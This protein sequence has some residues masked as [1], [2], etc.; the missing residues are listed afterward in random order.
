MS[1]LNGKFSIL[2]SISSLTPSFSDLSI[3]EAEIEF[4]WI[5][6]RNLNITFPFSKIA[7]TPW[8]DRKIRFVDNDGDQLEFSQISLD[9]YSV[10]M[11]EP[12]AVKVIFSIGDSKRSRTVRQPVII[13]QEF[14]DDSIPIRQRLSFRNQNNPKQNYVLIENNCEKPITAEVTIDGQMKKTEFVISGYP[15]LI[16]LI[17]RKEWIASTDNTCVRLMLRLSGSEGNRIK[18]DFVLSPPGIND[19]DTDLSDKRAFIEDGCQN[20]ELKFKELPPGLGHESIEIHSKGIFIDSPIKNK[21]LRLKVPFK[22]SERPI[23]FFVNKINRTYKVESFNEIS[24]AS[25]KITHDRKNISFSGPHFNTSLISID[26]SGDWEG[27]LKVNVLTYNNN[28]W[29]SIDPGEHRYP[30]RNNRPRTISFKWLRNNLPDVDEFL[31]QNFLQ[32]DLRLK[33]EIFS[34]YER[35]PISFTTFVA[36]TESFINIIREPYLVEGLHESVMG[37]AELDYA[38]YPPDKKYEFEFHDK[39]HSLTNS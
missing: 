17:T 24:E 28:L 18:R 38:Q 7:S 6:L 22:F 2:D 19:Y 8:D 1:G 3:E 23:E 35:S 33:F 21:K 15:N 12:I 34:G 25:C 39:K 11:D 31:Q 4:E 29:Q 26:S 14:T 32:R 16:A 13:Q 27:V 9:V 30:I 37:S 20:I 36:K 10:H 5:T